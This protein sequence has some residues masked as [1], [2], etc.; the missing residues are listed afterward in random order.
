MS[1]ST[2]TL[3]WT[4][5]DD[6]QKD[7]DRL[8]GWLLWSLCFCGCG[9]TVGG[10]HRLPPKGKHD[11]SAAL[12]KADEEIELHFGVTPAVLRARYNLTAS[13][14]G[15]GQNNSQAVAQVSL[16]LSAVFQCMTL[17]IVSNGLFSFSSWSSTTALQTCL[18]S[19]KSLAGAS[20][21]T[22]RWNGL[23]A[24][25]VMERPVWKPVWISSTS[26]A[27]EQTSPPGSSPIQVWGAFSYV[28][29][30]T[31][32]TLQ[33]FG[34]FCFIVLT[35]SVIL[36][37]DTDYLANGEVEHNYILQYIAIIRCN[38]FLVCYVDF[39]ILLF[40]FHWIIFPSGRHE[41]QEPFLQWMVLLSNMSDLPWIHTISYGD[42]EDSLSTAYM[43]RINTEFMK[44]GVRG[45]S[46]L[47]ASGQ[48]G[49]NLDVSTFS[50]L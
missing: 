42:D 1:T 41:S 43:M 49:S 44:A 7:C 19:W 45:I 20:S 39:Y 15:G 46:L 3:V 23:W 2:F 4:F 27:Q 24:L 5:Y 33:L 25:R 26:W 18:S 17:G 34:F 29:M 36:S 37:I 40:K 47:F 35:N 6:W 10:L 31:A 22:L 28:N 14:V 8:W 9:F 12:S 32:Q 11:M 38:W 13:D 30:L 16:S 21:I 50:T 48:W